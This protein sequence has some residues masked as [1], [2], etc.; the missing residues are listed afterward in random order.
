MFAERSGLAMAK[1][2]ALLVMVL[3]GISC[4]STPKVNW[5]SRVGNYTFDQAV[6]EMGPPERASELSDGTKVAE[7]FLKRGS[8]MS[9]GVGTG[10]YGSGSRVGVGQSVV[11]GPSGQ[12]LRLTFAAG[13]VLSR[14]EKVWR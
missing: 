9:V 5:D 4:A 7:W 14:W 11:T 8:S 6:L 13:G 10:F 2:V 12:Y 1:V 3:L